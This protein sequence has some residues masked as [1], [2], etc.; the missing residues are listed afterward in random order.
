MRDVTR[1]IIS[2][3][4]LLL[5]FAL[6]ACATA[7]LA[8]WLL[9]PQPDPDLGRFSRIGDYRFDADPALLLGMRG[10]VF[11]L[12]STNPPPLMMPLAL[13]LRLPALIGAQ[14]LGLVS[15]SEDVDMFRQRYLVGALPVAVL[16][17][18]VVFVTAR[19]SAAQLRR[20]LLSVLIAGLVAVFNPLSAAALEWG[21][22]EELQMSALVAAALLALVGDRPR[23]AAVLFAAAAA[24]KQ[25]ALLLAPAFFFC[26][27]RGRRKE[28]VLWGAGTFA[29]FTLPF[30]VA[31]FITFI[32]SNFLGIASTAGGYD[33]V[34]PYHFFDFVGLKEI[35][36]VGRPI[37][38]L[39]CLAAP[40]LMARKSGWVIDLRRGTLLIALLVMLRAYLDPY[41]INYYAAPAALAL[42]VYEWLSW[43]QNAWRWTRALQ[44]K[45]LPFLPLVT[46]AF[47]WWLD[48]I[49]GGAIAEAAGE[50]VA[51][52]HVRIYG[53]LC[54]ATICLLAAGLFMRD[55]RI[56][57][58][59]VALYGI[60]L[61]CAVV[62][63]ITTVATYKPQP[64]DFKPPYGFA[65]VTAESAAKASERLAADIY[66]LSQAPP[67]N[68]ERFI[69]YRKSKR[70]QQ[71]VMAMADYGPLNNYADHVSDLEGV[72]INTFW[73]GADTESLRET[74]DECR[75]GD[76]RITQSGI[77]SGEQAPAEL[78]HTLLGPGLIY[79]GADGASEA[80]ILAGDQVV[81]VMAFGD[82]AEQLRQAALDTLVAAREQADC[83]HEVQDTVS[84]QLPEAP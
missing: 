13:L 67:G 84:C 55:R 53:V 66:F 30:V 26:L 44:D 14:I 75:H 52:N 71:N 1:R 8:W 25:P 56:D 46:L 36:W 47:A 7:G 72:T 24:T 57:R 69:S 45:G 18:F 78:I 59:R 77:F 34:K 29:V 48:A 5:L 20:P 40:V 15:L 23:V 3:W 39:V 31:D 27:P 11:A 10:D 62:I 50:Y 16:A 33:E 19:W 58:S 28:L 61:L 35:E 74:I 54:G 22:P 80:K 42:L 6:S 68:P 17:A 51:G 63:A 65:A 81:Y 41:N 79:E 83:K 43:R 4:P 64:V 70:K 76:C 2:H 37:V 82:Q 49:T 38:Y 32:G 60:G 21:H 12:Y 73:P 9:I